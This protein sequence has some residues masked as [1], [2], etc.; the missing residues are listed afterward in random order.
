[1][2][3]LHTT[4][5]AFLATL[6]FFTASAQ[7]NDDPAA[8][9]KQ[10]VQ[11]NTAGKYAEAIEK[12]NQALKLDSTYLFAGYQLA[13][14][15]SLSGKGMDGVPYLA[16]IIKANTSLAPAAY[17]LLGDIYDKNHQPVKAIEAYTNGT[18]AYPA[19]KQL[20]YNFGLIYWHNRQYG[21]AE[22]CSVAALK[23]D[24]AYANAQRMYA[25][26]T[27][28]QNKRA[29][30]LL[31]LCSFIVLEPGT[32]KSAEAY[33][34]IQHI[35]QGGALKP[36]PG[37]TA[38][39]AIDANASA[40]NQAITQAVS[41]TAKNKFNTPADLLAAQLMAIFTAIGQTAEKQTGDDFFRKYMAAYFYKLAQSPNMPAFARLISQSAPESAQWLKD[42]P[43]QMAALNDW[44]KSTERLY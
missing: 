14:S 27:F 12:Y 44:I 7:S 22:K 2:K 43:Q 26:V 8:L 30:A 25:L 24:P 39:R 1:M 33:G 32:A 28:H 6:L 15:L 31:G 13:Y 18:T 5:L 16:K 4:A 41:A 10:G 21:E 9:V 23:L 42:N 37:E 29:E 40:L 19:D 20:W 38:P 11:L 17:T 36:E 3:S 34:N 35:L